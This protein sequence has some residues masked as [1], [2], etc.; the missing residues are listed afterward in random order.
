MENQSEKK[1]NEIGQGKPESDNL[2]RH[3]NPVM[4]AGFSDSVIRIIS[5]CGDKY[6]HPLLNSVNNIEGSELLVLPSNQHYYYAE[7]D[8]KNI[9]TLIS[10]KKLNHIKH[11]VGFLHILFRT[12]PADAE[13]IGC[14]SDD[15][16]ESLN[17]TTYYKPSRLLKWVVNFIDSRTDHFMDRRKVSELLSSHGFKVVEMRNIDGL[18]YFYSRNMRQSA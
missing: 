15:K 18:T 11:P 17:G 1:Y 8:L 16:T 10:L 2:E 12:L 13:F 5:E 4:T 7:E 9:K 14:F 6:D 3:L